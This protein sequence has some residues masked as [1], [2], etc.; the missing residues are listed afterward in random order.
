[1]SPLEI[2]C[3]LELYAL[4]EPDKDGINQHPMAIE[5]LIKNGLIREVDSGIPEHFKWTLTEKGKRHV[6][7]LCGLPF[8]EER[9]EWVLPYK[10]QPTVH[11]LEEILA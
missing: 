6:E 11:E 8:P 9:T 5:A 1:M 4:A 2:H 3:L 7:S 10:R